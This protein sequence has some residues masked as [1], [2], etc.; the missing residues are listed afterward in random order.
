MSGASPENPLTAQEADTLLAPLLAYPHLALA[1]SGGPDSTG[2]MALVARWASGNPRAP[3]VSVLT[4]D[5]GLRPESAGEAELVCRQAGR[6][7]LPCRVLRWRGEKPASGIQQA[8][9][10]ARYRLMGEWCAEHGAALV[11]A[12]TLEDQAETFLMRLARGSGV[13]G[14]SS[15]AAV[16]RTGGGTPLLR[17]CLGVSGRRLAATARAAGLEW[18]NDPSNRDTSYERVRM[19]KLLPLL[20]EHGLS[21]EAMAL[22]AS[23]LGRARGALEKAADEFVAAHVTCHP[24]GWGEVE[25]AALLEA[26]EEVRLRV[27]A[28]MA[29]AFGGGGRQSLAALEGLSQWLTGGKGRA[30]TLSGARFARRRHALICGREPGRIGHEITLSATRTKAV[31]DG[32]FEV[33]LEEPRGSLTVR[34][35]GHARVDSGLPSRPREVPAFVWQSLPVACEGERAIAFPRMRF[36]RCGELF[37]G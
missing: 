3:S 13:D 1:V 21:A 19:R 18:V 4:V 6:L 35:L 36:L 27:L 30:R 8:A 25:L 14:L 33:S 32:R 37:S 26:P 11:T 34:A 23:R 28:R 5:H 9:R 20:A 7:G 17:P 12:H 29:R 15:M 10:E 31:W 24:Q 16:S 22:S 2:L